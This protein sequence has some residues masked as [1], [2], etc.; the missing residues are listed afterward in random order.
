MKELV[1]SLVA[2]ERA[3]ADEK[4]PLNLFALFLR[5]DAPGKW[6]L[7]VAAPWAEKN[8]NDAIKYIAG[9]IQKSLT[10]KELLSLSRVVIIEKSNPALS[11]FQ[12]AIHVEHGDAEIQD[13]NLFG[14]QIKHAHVITSQKP[15]AA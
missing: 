14:L 11:A 4:G 5:E 2:V 10:K 7:L 6:D 15:Q 1:K 9:K 8:K 13:S 12:K 3:L